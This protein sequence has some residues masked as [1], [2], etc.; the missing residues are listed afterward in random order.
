M[1]PNI[2]VIIVTYNGMQWIDRCIKSVIDSSLQAKILLIDN[3][4]KD[5]TKEY[6][7]KNY[8]NVIVLPNDKNIGFGKANNI[9]IKYALT[10]DCDFVYLLNQDA[11]IEKDT[12]QILINSINQNN[13]IGIISPL[14]VTSDKLK[15]DKNFSKYCNTDSCPSLIDDLLLNQPLKSFYPIDFVMA[16]H[17]LLTKECIKKIGG[18]NPSFPHYGE[19]DNYLHRLK[20]YGLIYGICP[21]TK[22][23]HD[24]ECRIPTKKHI[25]Y[26]N[27]IEYIKIYSNINLKSSI[28]FRK[29]FR[30]IITSIRLCFSHLTIE[31]IIYLFKFIFN[32]NKYKK[33]N[34][35]SKLNTSAFL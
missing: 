18:F 6:I 13:N 30:N 5:G 21:F 20:Y 15:L 24:R 17:W 32:L 1:T 35:I 10:H 22:A 31:P 3:G 34:N 29:I 19:D 9:G 7:S 14:Q 11:W 16:A 12:F 28:K 2:F 23:V 27:Y 8:P 25:I 26:M 4:S 33:N